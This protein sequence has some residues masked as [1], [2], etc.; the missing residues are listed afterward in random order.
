[1][2]PRRPAI[3]FGLITVLTS[4]LTSDIA[5][6]H[7]WI[8]SPPSRQ[9][10]CAK[11]RTSFDCGAIRWEPQSVEAPKGSLLCSGGGSFRILDESWRPWPVTNV[12]STVALHWKLTAAHRT[13]TWQYFVDGRLF[14]TVNQR[15][16]I[17]PYNFSHTLSGLPGGRHTILARWNVAD[18]AM[19]F[20]N[21]IDVNVGGL[22][23]ACVESDGVVTCD[24]GETITDG[25]AAAA[26]P[27]SADDGGCNA[28]GGG[29]GPWHAL[30]ALYFCRHR[31]RRA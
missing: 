2:R 20:Y 7:G 28:T 31:R 15:N 11:T 29:L 24:D 12:G 13:S 23:G 14:K 1:M 4:L 19:A 5:L 8:T 21:C 10:H 27:D 25:E 26:G 9:D 18:T 16:T 6:G 17:P 3:V 22:S 30:F